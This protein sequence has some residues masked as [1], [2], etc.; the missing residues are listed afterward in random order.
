MNIKIRAGQNF[1]FDVPVSGE[2]PPTKE[3]FLEGNAVVPAENIKLVNEDYNTKLKVVNAQR[4]DSG[5]YTLKAK[6]KNGTDSATV[7]VTVLDVPLPPEGK[8]SIIF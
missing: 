6:N 4:A 5:T 8:T 1:E 2:P 3:W 7:V